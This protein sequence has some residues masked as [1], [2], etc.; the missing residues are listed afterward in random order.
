MPEQYLA[1]NTIEDV[2]GQAGWMFSDM[3]VALMVVFLATISF[4][5][6]YIGGNSS[7]FGS[8]KNNTNSNV[9]GNS[10]TY[11]EHFDR[12]FVKVYE[13]SDV[14]TMVED[15]KVFLKANGIPSN[16]VID[17]AQFVGGYDQVTEN[18]GMAIQRATEF[19]TRL[20]RTY[21]GLLE[22]AS[23][24]LSSSPQLAAN[25]VTIRLTFSAQVTVSRD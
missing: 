10:Y 15:I 12:A 22:H 3:L 21:K 6:Q 25:L 4:I 17:S 7:I 20:E 14:S 5:P 1:E 18:S 11:S 8:D 16:A 2:S 13:S 9:G 23:T 24:V 19:S